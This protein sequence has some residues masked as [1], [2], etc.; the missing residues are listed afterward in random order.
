VVET[1]QRERQDA[2]AWYAREFSEKLTFP[3]GI[4]IVFHAL[5]Q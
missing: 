2:D 5:T 4:N 1:G 3:M